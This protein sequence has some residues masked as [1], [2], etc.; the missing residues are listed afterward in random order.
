MR[1][2]LEIRA[3]LLTPGFSGD[4]GV[5]N[6]PASAENTG[7]VPDPGRSHIPGSN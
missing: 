5:K 4:S 1:L 7:S 6:T 2:S 3:E